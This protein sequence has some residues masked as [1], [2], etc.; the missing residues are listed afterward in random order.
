MDSFLIQTRTHTFD[1]STTL[2]PV[3]ALR[4]PEGRACYP[5]TLKQPVPY[6]VTGMRVTFAIAGILI[7]GALALAVGSRALGTRLALTPAGP[8]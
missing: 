1:R 5:W 3:A 6:W 4:D 7:V 8:A 2:I